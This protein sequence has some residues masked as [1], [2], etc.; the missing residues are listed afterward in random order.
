M[1]CDEIV[2]HSKSLNSSWNINVEINMYTD[3]DKTIW[4]IGYLELHSW[5]GAAAI[6]I[7][8]NHRVLPALQL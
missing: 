8:Q 5:D 7:A 3:N 2:V 6:K 4:F 1:P